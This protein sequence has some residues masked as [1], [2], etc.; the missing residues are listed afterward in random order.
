MKIIEIAPLDN[1]AHRN[2]TG[3]F[4]QVPAG[5][6][7]I[8]DDMQIPDTFPFVDIEVTA[9]TRYREV[10]RY[11]EETGETTIEQVPYTVPVV[12]KM[13]AGVMP[14]PVPQPEPEPSTDDVLNILLGVD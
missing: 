1:G 6:A 7:Q 4:S 12:S 5:F 3:T 13:T 10:S 8:P 9:E 14:D 2:Q 11:N